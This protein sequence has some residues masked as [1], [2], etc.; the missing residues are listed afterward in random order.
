MC[1]WCV[2]LMCCRVRL[3]AMK[4]DTNTRRGAAFAKRLLQTAAI[5][6]PSYTCAALL[7]LSEALKAQP[8]LWTGLLQPEDHTL[9][10]TPH[11]HDSN[12]TDTHTLANGK[13]SSKGDG[14]KAGKAN[15]KSKQGNAK[16]TAAAAMVEEDG[17]EHFVDAPDTSDDD[18]AAPAGAAAATGAADGD[19]ARRESHQS[20]S[21]S[22]DRPW[23]R[24]GY[25]DMHKR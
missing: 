19:K 4:A 8:A 25:Y 2:C 15:N 9:T 20:A 1:V 14:K 11:T 18:A 5:A 17:E 23:P 13:A 3:Q 22:G 7:L 10:H 24:P 12:P 21:T 16:G 6:P